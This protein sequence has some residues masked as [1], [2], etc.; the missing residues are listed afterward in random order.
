MSSNHLKPCLLQNCLAL[1]VQSRCCCFRHSNCRTA[2]CHFAFIQTVQES[3]LFLCHVHFLSR[4][5]KALL[6]PTGQEPAWTAGRSKA[7][8]GPQQTFYPNI[9]KR[10]K[11][12]D[13]AIWQ[14]YA[15]VR[16]YQNNVAIALDLTFPFKEFLVLWP[17]YSG[18]CMFSFLDP[19]TLR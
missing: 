17:S 10:S 18:H 19:P 16:I 15:G 12:T 9:S 4:S 7:W 13:Q 1:A 5:F 6:L 14:E 3:T 8:T 11:Q 2:A